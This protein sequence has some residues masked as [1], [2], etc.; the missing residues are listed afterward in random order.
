MNFSRYVVL[1]CARCGSTWLD[2]LIA[3]HTCAISQ[4]ENLAIKDNAVVG[5]GASPDEWRAAQDAAFAK[6]EA[7]ARAVRHKRQAFAGCDRVFVGG[8]LPYEKLYAIPDCSGRDKP[9]FW[10]TRE[11]GAVARR[12]Y[13]DLRATIFAAAEKTKTHLAFVTYEDM[14][15]DEKIVERQLLPFLGLP[16]APHSP[17]LKRSGELAKRDMIGRHDDALAR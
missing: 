4:H 1:A 9:C 6:I 2:Q 13:E 12:A 3:S 15:R 17:T 8:K 5:A 16:P 10:D 7:E 11:N 14:L